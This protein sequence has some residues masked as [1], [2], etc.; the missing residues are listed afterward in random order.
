MCSDG[1]DLRT[2]CVIKR[3]SLK[4][5]AEKATRTSLF[6]EMIPKMFAKEGGFPQPY[7]AVGNVLNGMNG[8]GPAIPQAYLH[9]IPNGHIYLPENVM[10]QGNGEVE[11]ALQIHRRKMLRRAANRRSAQLS[12]ARKKVCF[13]FPV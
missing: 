1:N 8:L 3:Q 2:C 5:S 13:H 4:S 11:S 12:R 9:N 10:L 7:S 6:R